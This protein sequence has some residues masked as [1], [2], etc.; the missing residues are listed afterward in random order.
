MKACI[1]SGLDASQG[2]NSP[3]LFASD[4]RVIV[5]DRTAGSLAVLQITLLTAIISLISAVIGLVAGIVA[6]LSKR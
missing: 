2:L 6:L 1:L 5:Q 3:C 4:V